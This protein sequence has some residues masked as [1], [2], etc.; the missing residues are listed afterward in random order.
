MKTDVPTWDLDDLAAIGD[1]A[2]ERGI[3]S[4]A[5][6]GWRRYPDFPKPL[7]E[8]ST[9]PVYSRTQVREWQERRWPE[10]APGHGKVRRTSP[11]ARAG[12]RYAH[13]AADLR[14]R[15]L[16][17]EWPPGSKLP[18]RLKLAQRYGVGERVMARPIA[19]LCADGLLTAT[20]AS[21]TYVAKDIRL[22]QAT[23]QPDKEQP[24]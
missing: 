12:R 10:G 21:G 1:L 19:D 16:A 3:S 22:H 14:A 18:S 17:G 9:G 13:I 6:T 23:Q 7:I 2:R 24:A 11:T 8:L 15:I 4:S 20:R 5:A